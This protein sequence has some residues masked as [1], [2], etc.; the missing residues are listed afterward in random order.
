M[1][2]AKFRGGNSI[3]LHD[4]FESAEGGGRL[5]LTLAEAIGADLAYGF[6]VRG[7]QYFENGFP[8]KEFSVSSQTKLPIWKQYRLVRDFQSKTRFLN[9][10]HVAIYSGFYTPLAVRNHP[11][12]KNIYYCHTPPRF[13]YDQKDFYFSLIPKWQHPLLQWFNNYLQPRYEEA[14]GKMD[15]V[16]T[17]SENVQKRIKKYL[18]LDALVVY[19]P[20]S[21]EKFQWLGQGDYYLSTA[22]LDPL[23]RVDLII[24]AFKRMPDKKLIVAS[25]GPELSKL[26]KMA[27]NAGNIFLSG[28]LS[29]AKYKELLGF[30][31]ATIYI[32]REEDFG[33]SPVE[34][35]AAGKPVLGVAE[36][37]LI[38]S[39]VDG[40]TG[41]L[42]KSNFGVQDLVDAVGRIRPRSAAEMRGACRERANDFREQVFVEKMQINGEW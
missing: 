18:G 31:I 39:V 34:S 42:I 3:V 12:G 36:G 41:I 2:G 28:W 13:L 26:K 38:E 5:S 24:E 11:Q 7:H 15:L 32:P 27:G 8:G 22:R 14:V 35:M 17:N 4:Y 25:S 23:K 33:M 9:K 19:P 16:L 10:Y 6:K 29:E 20:C 30:C 21:V 40:E 1:Q 37:G